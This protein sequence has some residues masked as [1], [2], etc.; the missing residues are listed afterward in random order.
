MM[1]KIYGREKLS[2]LDKVSKI[3]EKLSLGK[4]KR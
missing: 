2:E 1:Y 3:T 4:E